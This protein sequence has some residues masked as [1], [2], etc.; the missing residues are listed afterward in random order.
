MQQFLFL[1]NWQS[2]DKDLT[3][4]K[5][6]TCYAIISLH[7]NCFQTVLLKKHFRML[8]LVWPGHTNI[9]VGMAL[10]IRLPPPLCHTLDTPLFILCVKKHCCANKTHFLQPMLPLKGAQKMRS[11][12]R[13]FAR[14]HLVSRTCNIPKHWKSTKQEAIWM[15][16]VLRSYFHKILHLF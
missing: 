6:R 11:T 9:L 13:L 8:I 3:P 16:C 1:K 7:V 15:K 10:A 12:T 4:T 14:W 2:V 5:G